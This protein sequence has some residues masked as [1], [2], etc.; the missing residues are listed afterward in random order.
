MELKVLKQVGFEEIMNIKWNFSKVVE[1]PEF[2]PG[3]PVK[4]VFIV[5]ELETRDWKL[6]GHGFDCLFNGDQRKLWSTSHYCS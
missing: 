4:T 2:G 6:G 1:E 3:A 5:G